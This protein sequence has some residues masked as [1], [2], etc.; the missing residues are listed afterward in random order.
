LEDKA[1]LFGA[2]LHQGMRRNQGHFFAI[3][4]NKMH[5]FKVDDMKVSFLT[6]PVLV[7]KGPVVWMFEF[8]FIQIVTCLLNL[9]GHINCGFSNCILL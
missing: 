1:D 5:W 2:I 9:V 4:R 8:R 6:F 7:E 3:L